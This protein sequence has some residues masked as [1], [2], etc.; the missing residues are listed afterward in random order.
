MDRQNDMHSL[1]HDLD[2]SQSGGVGWR[3]SAPHP[4]H[5]YALER[6]YLQ[7]GYTFLLLRRTFSGWKVLIFPLD[8]S[9][10]GRQRFWRVRDVKKCRDCIPF[11]PVLG[12]SVV[13][14]VQF[15]MCGTNT[16]V[17]RQVQWCSLEK[18][19]SSSILDPLLAPEIKE[20]E[21]AIEYALQMVKKSTVFHDHQ[22]SIMC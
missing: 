1:L 10:S 4:S 16:A 7:T 3:Q 18:I 6:N 15:E 2:D 19:L 11:Q 21:M 22:V 5:I 13:K 20:I 8:G 17:A 9:A 12:A 14:L